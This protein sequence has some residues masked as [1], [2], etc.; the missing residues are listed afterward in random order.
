MARHWFGG[1]QADQ[2]VT[3]YDLGSHGLVALA[4]GVKVT[5]FDA[6]TDGTQYVDL[7][8][9]GITPGS[10]I[11]T[12]DDG[13][14]PRFQGP[15]AVQAMWADVGAGQPRRIMVTTDAAIDLSTQLAS[16]IAVVEKG[17]VNGVAELDGD[18]KIVQPVPAALLEGTILDAR[19]PATVVRE[20]ELFVNVKDH[21][22][23]GDGT[24]DDRAAILAAI[25]AATAGETILLPDGGTYAIDAAWTISKSVTIRGHGATIKK[26]GATVSGNWCLITANDVHFE[27]IK[28][29]DPSG[30]VTG[31]LLNFSGPSTTGGRVER[32]S[33]NCP[34]AIAVRAVGAIDYTVRLNRITACREGF[35]LEANT[36]RCRI[37]RNRI[38]GWKNRGI[39]MV[40]TAA[41]ASIDTQL[42]GNHIS[43]MV[44]GGTVRYPIT[45]AQGAS[46]TQHQDMLVEGNT[47]IGENKS[48]GAADPGNSDLFGFFGVTNLLIIGNVARL[49]GD[50][51]ITVDGSSKYVTVAGNVCTGNDVAGI[52]VWTSCKAVSVTGNVCMNNGRNRN[53]DVAAAARAGIRISG[54]QDVTVSGNSLGD[55]QGTKTQLYGVSIT[56]STDVV[57][58]PDVDAGNS[59]ALYL[60]EA[61]NTSLNKVT[62]A[63][64]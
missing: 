4:A 12:D 61:G 16:R 38:T 41:G 24:T 19:I 18:G 28:F 64:F 27:G 39:Y 51:G 58:G 59:T 13:Y 63:A 44:A 45:T 35:M 11:T 43:G 30:I 17:A 53:S 26:I 36:L 55:D 15:D 60:N 9:D 25:T 6:E 33:F 46:A 62:L 37:E 50:M 23:V 10:F 21:G 42:V 34:G 5:F 56:G 47:I 57:C 52:A 20:G 54:A 29:E 32:C 2:V 49:G 7:L 22:A 31:N 14:V 1:S 48:H 8:L 3:R 40:G